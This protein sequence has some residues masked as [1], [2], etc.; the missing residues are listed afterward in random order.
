MKLRNLIKEHDATGYFLQDA[1]N[2]SST[3]NGDFRYIDDEALGMYGDVELEEL[4]EPHVSDDGFY[5]RWASD[6]I[7]VGEGDNPLRV[8]ILF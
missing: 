5:C 3:T 2:G 7:I 1:G 4:N 8:R 6:W